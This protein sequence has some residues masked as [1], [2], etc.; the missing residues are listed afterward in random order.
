MYKLYKKGFGIVECENEILVDRKLADG[1][2]FLDEVKEF[3]ETNTSKIE[4]KV[5]SCATENKIE[6]NASLVEAITIPQLQEE[7]IKR[8]GRPR[9]PVDGL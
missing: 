3:E 4:N 2:V 9:K 6:K 5:I 1:F 8:R 7:T